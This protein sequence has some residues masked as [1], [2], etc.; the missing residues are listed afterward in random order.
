MGASSQSTDI[1]YPAVVLCVAP[2][3][4]KRNVI[5]VSTS[6]S[7]PGSVFPDVRRPEIGLNL[8]KFGSQACH[9]NLLYVAPSLLLIMTE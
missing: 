5:S 2:D 9:L 4:S 3:E 7:I 1:V 8:R 6:Y